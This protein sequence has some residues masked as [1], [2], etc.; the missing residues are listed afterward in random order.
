MTDVYTLHVCAT[1]LQLCLTLCDPMDYSLQGSSVH[2]FQ[3]KK[4]GVGCRAILQRIFPAQGLNPSL[5][6]L[7]HWQA[8]DVPLEPL[9]S[10]LHLTTHNRCF[11]MKIGNWD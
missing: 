1:L 8:G 7:L 10:R 4:T 2:D 3:G 5:L 9:G 6:I 11:C